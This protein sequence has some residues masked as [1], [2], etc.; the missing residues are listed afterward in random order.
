MACAPSEDS[1]KTGH[2][3]SLIRVFSVHMRKAEVLSYH[4]SAQRSLWSYW[5]DAQA[6]LS[7]RWAR[8]GHFVSFVT[9]RLILLC[10]TCV[11]NTDFCYFEAFYFLKL[12]EKARVFMYP[13]T[14]MS[15]F[16]MSYCRRV[17][18]LTFIF[19]D[20]LRVYCSYRLLV[21]PRGDVRAVSLIN[22]R[23]HLQG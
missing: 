18:I 16:I 5:V 20:G 3:R 12:S 7:L 4:Y 14:C 9:R 2:P 17:V 6:D 15:P 10:L 8:K 19:H 22:E 1:D 23:L 21:G 13:C 11:N